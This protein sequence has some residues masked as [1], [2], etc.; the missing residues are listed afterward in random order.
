MP[1]TVVPLPRG[2]LSAIP[3]FGTDRL[4]KGA[5]PGEVTSGESY[6]QGSRAQPGLLWGEGATLVTSLQVYKSTSLQVYKSTSLQVILHPPFP[7]TPTRF[8]CLIDYLR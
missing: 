3:D 8:E 2:R 7:R 6:H 1:D 4:Q 5:Q